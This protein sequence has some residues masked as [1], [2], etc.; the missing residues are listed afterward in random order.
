MLSPFTNSLISI[1][2]LITRIEFACIVYVAGNSTCCASCPIC[3]RSLIERASIIML[4]NKVK[5]GAPRASPCLHAGV[6]AFAERPPAGSRFGTQAW[7]P[8][9]IPTYA[10]GRLSASVRKRQGFGG[11]SASERNPP[12]HDRLIA[13]MV[14]RALT[15]SSTAKAVVSCVGG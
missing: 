15:H 6:H 3:G 8:K 13:E 2:S 5:N 9:T 11:S 4:N 14:Y 7:S 10:P 12:K 1:T